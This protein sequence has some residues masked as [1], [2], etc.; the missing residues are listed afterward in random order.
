MSE[1]KT[2]SWCPGGNWTNNPASLGNG[3]RQEV[4]YYY[5]RLGIR[6]RAFHWHRNWWWPIDLGRQVCLVYNELKS[7]DWPRIS[8]LCC[9]RQGSYF[10]LD[11]L[12]VSR[13]TQ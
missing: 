4:N 9:L 3:E 11:C 8:S 5:S 12:S 1:L 10:A 6:I 7:C 13:N 2:L